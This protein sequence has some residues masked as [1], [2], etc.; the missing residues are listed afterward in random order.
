VNNIDTHASVCE[1]GV[2]QCTACWW[3]IGDR[4]ERVSNLIKTYTCMKYQGET[5][6]NS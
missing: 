1:D 4:G 3:V 5:P 6:L 2:V